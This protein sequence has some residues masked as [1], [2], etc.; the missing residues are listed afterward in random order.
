MGLKGHTEGTHTPG[1]AAL[2]SQ[3]ILTESLH[4]TKVVSL[5]CKMEFPTTILNETKQLRG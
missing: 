3:D 5:V 1:S 2:K 4:V